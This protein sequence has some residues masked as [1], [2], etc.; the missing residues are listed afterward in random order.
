MMRWVVPLLCLV[1]VLA[2]AQGV[3]FDK[4]RVVREVP[5]GQFIHLDASGRRS[6]AVAQH[7]VALTWEDNRNGSSSVYVAFK[8]LVGGDFAPA[9]KISKEGNAYEPAIAA[10][11]DDNFVI[12]WEADSRLWMRRV[13]AKSVG[14]IQA[15]GKINARQIS[16]STGAGPVA[17]VAWSQRDGAHYRIAFTTVSRDGRG[18]SRQPPRWVD[19]TT[20][21]NE[22]LYPAVAVCADGFTVGWEDRREGATRIYVAFA[23]RGGAFEHYRLLNDFT[24]SARPDLGHGTGAM[25]VGLASDGQHRVVASWLD[26]RHFEG[27]YD[28][29]AAF[30]DDGGRHFGADELVQDL[31]GE[32]TPQWHAAVAMAPQGRT[33]VAWDDQRD[34]TPDV[35]FS[36]KQA[37]GWSDDFI[38]GDAGGET[39]QRSPSLAFDA[40]GKLHAV[41]LSLDAR[42]PRIYYQAVRLPDNQP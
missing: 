11:D 28:V 20:D 12:G 39:A 4:S 31:L 42:G 23:S 34:G 22:Q 10:L 41:W 14:P 18:L 36:W 35:W 32:N 9:V 26:K 7:T 38:L 16:F 17:G 29:Y 1:P 15:L 25:R 13:S 19:A 27:G 2:A 8:P 37:S 33:V 3:E 30:S 21:R 5:Q 24:S 40:T 6:L